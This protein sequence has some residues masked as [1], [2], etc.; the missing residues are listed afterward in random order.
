[1]GCLKMP[2][3]IGPAVDGKEE[4]LDKMMLQNQEL[5]QQVRVLC[6]WQSKT[7]DLLRQDI[8]LL[9]ELRDLQKPAKTK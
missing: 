7:C 2:T 5:M 6:E 3:K 9:T 8:A 1:M 4:R